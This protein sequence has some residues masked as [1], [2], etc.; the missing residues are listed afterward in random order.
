VQKRA[1]RGSSFFVL[2]KTVSQKKI[3]TNSW[4]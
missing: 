2:E 4:I 3:V 1:T